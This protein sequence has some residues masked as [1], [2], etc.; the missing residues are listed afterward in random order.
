MLT[1]TLGS[2]GDGWSTEVELP[3]LFRAARGN[4][5]QSCSLQPGTAQHEGCHSHLFSGSGAPG[6][7]Q[8]GGPVSCHL[9]SHSLP[10]L[11]KER[12]VGVGGNF[13]F[14]FF[15]FFAKGLLPVSEL[16]LLA[17]ELFTVTV[18]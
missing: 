9:H 10:F 16:W 7:G 8:H 3:F 6:I 14:F 1:N 12:G 15:P 13:S 17:P 18:H 5:C 11:W 2:Q 4:P